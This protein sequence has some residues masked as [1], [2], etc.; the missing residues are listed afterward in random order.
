MLALPPR[1]V[2]ASRS[3]GQALGADSE[4]GTW[5]ALHD[6]AEL[7]PLR[8]PADRSE[9]ARGAASRIQRAFRA[10]LARA[11]A[12]PAVRG[13]KGAAL[14]TSSAA[15]SFDSPPFELQTRFARRR[16]VGQPV[17]MSHDSLALLPPAS[18]AS[19]AAKRAPPGAG[20]DE[21]VIR[22]SSP[23]LERARAYGLQP[24]V[25]AS[26]LSPVVGAERTAAGGATGVG[27]SFGTPPSAMRAQLR[28]PSAGGTKHLGAWPASDSTRATA[29]PSPARAADA[30][31][32]ASASP[33]RRAPGMQARPPPPPPLRA[34]HGSEEKLQSIL[35]FL[36]VAETNAALVAPRACA[37][38][39]RGSAAGGARARSPG[40]DVRARAGAGARLLGAE[41]GGT[42]TACEPAYGGAHGG[43]TASELYSGVKAKMASLKQQ[44]ADEST[45]AAQLELEL[46]AA[47]A[48]SARRVAEAEGAAA[49]RVEAA[50]GEHEL[51]IARHLGFIDRLL[52][53][54]TELARQVEALNAQS[55]ALETKFE[56][57]LRARDEAASREVR[58]RAEALAVSDR[59]KR[60]QWMA[61][62]AKEIKELTIRG[63][64]PDIQRLIE[65]HREEVR[66]LSEATRAGV[67]QAVAD[68]RAACA[69]ELKGASARADEAVE[70][71]VTRERIAGS[72]AVERVRAEADAAARAARKS[73]LSELEEVRELAEAARR[74]E[75]A[76]HEAELRELRAAADAQIADA[77]AAAA[78]GRQGASEAL[79]AERAQ[80]KREL[81][82][83]QAEWIQTQR[84]A[85]AAEAARKEQQLVAA[86]AARRDEEV[87][88][89]IAKLSEEMARTKRELEAAAHRRADE[90]TAAATRDAHASRQE[91]ADASARAEQANYM[92]EQ[93]RAQLDRTTAAAAE[94]ASERERLRAERGEAERAAQAEVD[95]LAR[96]AAE[97]RRDAQAVRAQLEQ[98]TAA[99]HA[100]KALLSEQLAELHAAHSGADQSHA[101]ELAELRAQHEGELARIEQRVVG[102][103]SRKD[104]MI[105]QLT[106][107]LNDVERMLE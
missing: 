68:E 54:K 29:P 57:R 42:P 103:I 15:G 77:R 3:A 71:A 53:D 86:A 87:S 69:R 83:E 2:L 90:L 41:L 19:D 58:R 84:A 23:A 97:A 40:A 50:K 17:E 104:E 65:K 47:R 89:V 27:T 55:S 80:L 79:H 76:R 82:A 31:P 8:R 33:R 21:L 34:V 62:K 101:A 61:A 75:A 74:R 5:A 43:T 48:E 45:R 100:E 105:A 98:R 6:S 32:A 88:R 20:L 59:A 96:A 28:S 107:R 56:A 51:A 44:L 78:A 13:A 18:T 46:A 12:A 24:C 38:G 36:D 22:S 106:A 30:E 37:G 4:Q 72:E 95:A 7:R 25:A 73:T 1:P 16:P 52:A 67:A 49:S 9:R 102:A 70:K 66:T 91:A 85:L 35:A 14:N 60:E 26:Q 99:A 81:E 92:Y 64:E 93:L 39:E 94:N 10:T 63:L 11:R